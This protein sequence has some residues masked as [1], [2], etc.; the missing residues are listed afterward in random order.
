MP[1]AAI[2]AHVGIREIGALRFLRLRR[3]PSESCADEPR[4]QAAVAGEVRIAL[5]E[6]VEKSGDQDGGEIAEEYE[7][8]NLREQLP[9]VLAKNFRIARAKAVWR[10]RPT[11]PAI[12]GIITKKRL[13]RAPRP[14]A[15]PAA[16]PRRMAII[17][18]AEK[19]ARKS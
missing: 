12:T 5:P 6:V 4:L 10:L 1:P 11:P 2:G 9:V 14:V 19:R 17:E 7:R 18:P 3:F 16:T 8:Q 15:H 13:R